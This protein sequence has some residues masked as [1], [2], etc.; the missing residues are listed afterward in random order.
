M[1]KI[2]LFAIAGAMVFSNAEAKKK[3]VVQVQPV[4]IPSTILSTEIDSISYALGMNLGADFGNYLQNMPG[5]KAN[6]ELLIKG[7]EATIKGD[8]NTVITKDLAQSVFQKY[9][10]KKQNEETEAK[11]ASGEKFLADNKVKAGVQTTSSGLQYLVIKSGMGEKPQLT[12]TV[13][14]H[15][16]GSLTDGTVFDSSLDRGEPI[17]FPLN[18]VIPGWTEGVQLMNVGAKYKFFIPYQLA[19]GDRGIPQA[20]IP[21]Y[22][23][24]VFEVELLGIKKVV[25]PAKVEEIKITPKS[26]SKT[27]KKK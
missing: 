3:P 24:L 14:V 6:K 23:P 10:M 16:T 22:A 8:T 25:P 19:Y 11:K 4:Q 27:T 1:K 13:K 20:G 12:D 7:F 18:G 17:E 26:S 21:P 15:Y 5:E 9:M 2:F